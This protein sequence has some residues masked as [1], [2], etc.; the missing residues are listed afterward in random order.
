MH[1][2][3]ISIFPN[4]F[5]SFLSTS[6]IHRAT[7][8]EKISFSITDPREFCTDKQRQVDDEIY[9]WWAWL[10]IKAEPMIA[11][12]K[13]I[14]DKIDRSTFRI[15]FPSPSPNAFTQ[16]TAHSYIDEWVTDII[17]LCGRYEWIDHRVELRCHDTFWSDIY[18]KIS[19]GQ[20]ITL[21]WELP[22][23][24][25]IEAIARLVPW[26][27]N[28]EASR[29]EESYR[30]ELWWKNIEYPQYTRPQIVQWYK[31]PDVLLSGHHA[32]IKKWR[33]EKTTQ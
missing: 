33:K 1:F 31:V 18:Q 21:W 10:L 32:E 29:Q 28:D 9:G 16:A 14:V 20:F 25:M 11:A 22:S 13:H 12:I 2:H 30:P 26:V 15:I 19:L 6:L 24:V 5:D 23:M 3:L 7:K 17:F 8:D 4:I 27:I